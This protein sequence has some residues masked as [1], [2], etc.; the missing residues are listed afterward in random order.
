M[1]ISPVQNTATTITS[2]GRAMHLNSSEIGKEAFWEEAIKSD[3]ARKAGIDA[4]VYGHTRRINGDFCAEYEI[5]GMPAN[6]ITNPIKE[7]HLENLFKNFFS[8]EKAG[9]LHKNLSLE[10]LYFANDGK[11]NMDGFRHCANF[12]HANG[13][14][15]RA[16]TDA[17]IAMPSNAQEFAEAGLAKYVTSIKSEKTQLRFLEDYLPAKAKYHLQRAYHLK[18]NEG[19]KPNDKAIQIELARAN[20]LAAPSQ[21]ILRNEL[22]KLNLY[23]MENRALE[24]WQDG[25]GKADGISKPNKRINSVLLL[26]DCLKYSIQLKDNADFMSTLHDNEFE[27]EYFKFEKEDFDHFNTQLMDC[28]KTAGDKTFTKK[29]FEKRPFTVIGSKSDLDVSKE[30]K[31]FE[32]LCSKIDVKLPYDEIKDNINSVAVRYGS[33]AYK[34]SENPINGTDSTPGVHYA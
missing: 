25:C 31:I 23:A 18:N 16:N 12:Y 4:P 20:A 15:Q 24:L 30:A 27:A 10:H 26:F 32:N 33:F 7:K 11:V 1:L 22:D 3:K 8:L 17:N 19:L 29:T 6:F 34:D 2:F 28:I 14:F 21:H 13:K 9:I 5:S